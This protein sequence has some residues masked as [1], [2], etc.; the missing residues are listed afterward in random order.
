[1]DL[2]TLHASTRIAYVRFVGSFFNKTHHH[3]RH[4]DCGILV[5]LSATNYGLIDRIVYLVTEARSPLKLAAFLVLWSVSILALVTVALERRTGL[6]CAWAFV[7]AAGTTAAVAYRHVADSDLTSVEMMTLWH[8]RHE[9]GRAFQAYWSLS[10]AAGLVFIATIT[11]FA[12]PPRPTSL[13]QWPRRLVGVLPILPIGLCFSMLLMEGGR[14]LTALP[15]QF[16]QAA[17]FLFVGSRIMTTTLPTRSPVEM[18]AGPELAKRIVLIVDESIRA[19]YISLSP[20][21]SATPHLADHRARFVDFGPAASGGNCSASSNAILRF[22]ATRHDLPRSVQTSP[23]IW[24]YAKQA[25]YRTVY[26]DGQ[27]SHIRMLG[28]V[29]GRSKLQNH[30]SLAETLD[31]DDLHT[32]D[33]VPD[34]DADQKVAEIIAREI[35]AD[36]KVFV[37]ANKNGAHFPYENA[38][39]RRNPDPSSSPDTSPQRTLLDHYRNAVFHS[40]SQFF[41]TFFD[42]ADLRDSVVFYTSDHGQRLQSGKTSHCNVI[43]PDAREALVPLL[44]AASDARLQGQFRKGAEIN[45]GR[46]DHFAIIPSVLYTMGYPLND[47]LA[48][49]GSSMLTLIETTP[50][51]TSGDVMGGIGDGVHWHA[52]DL[53]GDFLEPETE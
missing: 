11:L 46:A 51:F 31:I 32:F 10:L 21:N 30:M 39:P 44:V 20:G 52:I 14:R 41:K 25:G 12:W 40:V 19:D 8:V 16:A 50:S 45:L 29:G 47:V 2:A 3:Q 49:Y 35:K 1:M 33:D 24:R 34:S 18:A 7:I 15:Q 4:K 9:A 17:N 38:Y 48:H 23:S 37:Y 5:L 42:S 53:T 22:T 27:S 26:I 36:E 13:F 6:R 28:A 43:D